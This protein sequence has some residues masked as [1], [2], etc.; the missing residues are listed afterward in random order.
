MTENFDELLQE[1][2]KD[3][4]HEKLMNIWN[5]Y[6]KYFF[7]TVGFLFIIFF[8]LNRYVEN[9]RQERIFVSDKF[10]QAQEYLALKQTDKALKILETISSKNSKAYH[11]LARLVESKVLVDKG[12]DDF[13]KGQNT[14][15]ELFSDK[16]QEPLF[17][18]FAKFVYLNNEIDMITRGQDPE[19]ISE[20]T[21]VALRALLPM[22]TEFVSDKAPLRVLFLEIKG[23]IL[24]LLNQHEEATNEF[25]AIAQTAQCPRG[26]KLRADLMIEKIKTHIKN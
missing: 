24:L 16:K 2:Q 5:K 22:L 17:R 3:I 6:Q 13:K 7:Y 10:L 21:K 15:K 11:V 23:L 20:D 14:L 18:S 26:L 19:K 25:L 9:D 1:V 12:S 8:G 4:Q